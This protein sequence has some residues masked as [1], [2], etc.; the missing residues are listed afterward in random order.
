M[1]L[2]WK[3]QSGDLAAWAEQGIL[4]WNTT[5]TVRQEHLHLTKAKAGKLSQ[6]KSFVA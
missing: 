5:L 6:M 4:L 3:P 1:I 2:V